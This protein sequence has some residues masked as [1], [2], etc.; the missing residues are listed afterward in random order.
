MKPKEAAEILG[1]TVQRI[2]ILA[3]QKKIDLNDPSSVEAWKQNKGRKIEP[4]K[5][6]I[7][8]YM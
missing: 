1:V 2:Y 3:K 5:I 8:K 6:K 7:R 4:E